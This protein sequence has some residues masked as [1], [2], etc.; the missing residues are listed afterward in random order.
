LLD[1]QPVFE[2]VRQAAILCRRVQQEHIVRS[3]KAG[4]EPVTI[5]DYGSQAIICRAIAYA[6]PGDAILA[7]EQ[8]SQFVSLVSDVEREHIIRLVSDVLGE[9]V[10]QDHMVRW[11]DQG[12]DHYS[13]RTWV[14][15]P[16]DGTKGF[17]AQRRYSIAVGIVEDGKPTGAVLGS[18]GYGEGKLFFVRDGESFVEPLDGGAAQKIHV[19]DETNF[20]ALRVVESV[21][22]AHTDQG[23]TARVRQ[24]AGIPENVVDHIDSMDKYAMVACGDAELYVRLPKTRNYQ[25]KAWD[26]AAGTALVL[27]AGGMVTDVNGEPLDFSQGRTLKNNIG[28]VISNGK[29]H[30]RVLEAVKEV[31]GAEW[32]FA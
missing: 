15:D 13:G 22:L 9:S 4:F 30:D 31:M 21:E 3:D 2:A 29:I 19:S 5:A 14:I 8:G 27:A 26:H 10:T 23:L 12:Q 16:I 17:L 7:E 24:V 1:L 25:H 32:G 20:Q 11:L 6:F 28:M 18:P